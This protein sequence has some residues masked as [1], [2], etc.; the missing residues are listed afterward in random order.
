MNSAEQAEIMLKL[1]YGT[2]YNAWKVFVNPERKA[3]LFTAW[4]HSILSD[5][6]ND[7]REDAG[8]DYYD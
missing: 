7:L 4:E 1:K 8:I 2:I 6:D 3:G 5:Y